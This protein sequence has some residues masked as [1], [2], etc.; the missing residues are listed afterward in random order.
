LW[1]TQLCDFPAQA[2]HLA[3]HRDRNG[4]RDD[5]PEGGGGRD[6]P[7]TRERPGESA[8]R[9][10]AQPAE[11]AVACELAKARD[12]A[13][14]FLELLEQAAIGDEARL[15][16]LRVVFRQVAEQIASDQQ[17]A[18]AAVRQQLVHRAAR[19]RIVLARAGAT[20]LRRSA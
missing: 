7:R 9:A 1:R 17:V 10:A 5:E 18:L 14:G 2:A 8:A 3:V 4:D 20:G 11:T 6:G 12:E 19:G 13:L 15:E 16:R